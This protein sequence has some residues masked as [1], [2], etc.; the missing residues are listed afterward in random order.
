MKNYL[1]TIEELSKSVGLHEGEIDVLIR[2]ILVGSSDTLG[3]ARCNL[4]LF[5]EDQSKL[6]SVLA[7]TSSTNIFSHE[8]PLTMDQ[9]PN[10]FRFLKKNELIV[11]NNAREEPMNSELIAGYIDPNNITSMIDVPIRAEGKMIGVICFEHVKKEHQWT[12]DEQ[13]FTQAL[14]Q[15][16]SLALETKKKREYR[17]EL[18]KIVREKEVLISEINHRVKNNMAVII[19]LLNLQ[20]HKTQNSYHSK[21]FEEVK[22]K[23]FSMSMIQ[24]QLH[25]SGNIDSINLGSFLEDLIKNLNISYGQ[26]KNIEINLEM[27][28]IGIDVSRAIPCGLLANEILTNSFKY[29]FNEQ[30]LFPKLDISLSINDSHGHLTFRDNGPGF[31]LNTSTG[32]MGLV[33]IK[34]LAEQI[35]AKM[36]IFPKN[37][38]E[39]KLLIPIH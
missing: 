16:L 25:S 12:K 30:N 24:E 4:W 39:I 36:T 2:E 31:E 17:M 21:L 26:E 8:A 29:A 34:D 15:L 28:E 11:S 1:E 3:C 13:K 32:G 14:A 37:G 35:D 38:V 18:E 33:L 5:E 19:G 27:D 6:A 23:V 22:D 10:Y 20:K 7:Y 9:L